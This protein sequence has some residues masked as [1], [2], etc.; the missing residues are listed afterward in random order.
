MKYFAPIILASGLLC[1]YIFWPISNTLPILGTVTGWN[2]ETVWPEEAASREQPKLVSFY[3][4]NCPDI[5]PSTMIDLQNLQQ[6]MTDNGIFE[7]QYQIV[8]VTLDPLFDSKERILQ[9]REAFGISNSNWLFLR[10]SEQEIRNFTEEF[11][12]VYKKNEDGFLTHTI[13]MYVVDS[14]DQI[15]SRHDM[16]VGDKEVNIDEI[17]SHLKQLI[18]RTE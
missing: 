14:K 7:S 10:G 2:L 16:A 1:L 6:A 13:Y 5:C 12:F 17:V 11:N 18:N 4:T 9:Y 15:R 8:S 3:Y